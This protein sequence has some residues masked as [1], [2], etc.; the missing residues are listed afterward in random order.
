MDLP[1]MPP[2]S[3]MLAKSVPN[4]PEVGH[5]EPKWDGF[6]SIIFR[7]TDEVTLWSRHGKDLS[8]YS[9]RLQLR[10]LSRTIEDTANAEKRRADAEKDRADAAEKRLSGDG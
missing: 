8:R 10:Q 6:R 3:P 2:V 4:I 5:Y 1:V 7:D 9:V